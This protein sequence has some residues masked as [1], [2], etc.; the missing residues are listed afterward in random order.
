MIQRTKKRQ[1]PLT[2]TAA[3][4]RSSRPLLRRQ[5]FEIKTTKIVDI[6]I[7]PRCIVV[8]PKA[9]GNAVQRNKIKRQIRSLF[10]L[11]HLQKTQKHW[12]FFCKKGC[13]D[14]SY[15]DFQQMIEE[16]LKKGKRSL[17]AQSLGEGTHTIPEN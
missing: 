9:T 8:T 6:N 13:T 11:L 15:Q 3:I 17:T 7:S 2:K 10:T 14:Y 12:I 5:F 16:S 4:I 1:R